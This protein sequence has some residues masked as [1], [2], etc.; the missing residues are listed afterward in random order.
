MNRLGRFNE[1]SW[2]SKDKNYE[3]AVWMEKSGIRGELYKGLVVSGI[4]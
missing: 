1:K 4:H 3:I 2:V